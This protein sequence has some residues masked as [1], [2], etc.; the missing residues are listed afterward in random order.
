MGP[1]PCD[2]PNAISRT[3]IERSKSYVLIS[4]RMYKLGQD[5]ILRLCISPDEYEIVMTNAHISTGNQHVHGHKLAQRVLLDG[6]WWPTIH[7]DVEEYVKKCKTCQHAIPVMHATLFAITP[8]P[9]WS[10]FIVK[11]LKNGHMD[12]NLPQHH[13]K[14]IEVEASNYVLFENQLY[15]RGKD[16]TL[17][18]CVNKKDYLKVLSHAHFGVA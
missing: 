8:T 7:L 9:R 6:M 13:K 3:D 18:L 11:Y 14:A 5:G 2:Q 15:K 1:F 10:N 16:S 12:A 4:K 17:R